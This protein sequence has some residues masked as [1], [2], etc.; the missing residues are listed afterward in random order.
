MAWIGKA[1]VLLLAITSAAG[2]SEFAER[3]AVQLVYR[4]APLSA[5]QVHKNLAYWSGPGADSRRHRLD[6]YA[7]AKRGWPGVVFVHGGNW[8][9]GDKDLTFGGV[10]P[11]G[12]IGRFYAARG[13]G[14]AVINYRLQPAVDWRDQVLDVARAAAWLSI[15][16]PTYGAHSRAI[17]LFGH[18]AG[19]HLVARAGLDQ[20]VLDSVRLPAGLLCG[21]IA[22]SGAP[23][24][25]A[26]QRT[27]ELGTRRR[28]FERPFRGDDRGEQ[29][30][31][32]ASPRYHVTSS[33]PPFLLLY[34]RW[35][36]RGLKRQ[37]ELMH[38][39]LTAGRIAARLVQTPW[40]GHYVMVAALSRADRVASAEVIDFIR[41]ANCPRR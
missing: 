35:E 7:P 16:G 31:Y 20:K 11:Y 34:G 29:W 24:D 40:D 37:N 18:S 33:A 38:R 14:V 12:N 19:G 30:Q 1:I 27:Y 10:D 21:V 39:E 2:C 32:D 3:L 13:I 9:S 5:E 22:A 28:I 6:L 17:F 15:H 23:Y 41:T 26:D 25:I 4:E 36:T 8:R